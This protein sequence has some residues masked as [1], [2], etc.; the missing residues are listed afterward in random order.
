MA[1]SL[2][3]QEHL[4]TQRRIKAAQRIGASILLLMLLAALAGLFGRGGPMADARATQGP[5][6]VTAP[7]FAR[8]LAPTRIEVRIDRAPG[9]SV[10]VALQGE[11]ADAFH[12]RT[13]EPRPDRV[14]TTGDA[15]VYRFVAVPGRPHRM[16][17]DGQMETI[18]PVA[19]SVRVEGG[20]AVE[21]DT[22]VYP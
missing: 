20:P 16:R 5:L 9:D 1:R 22:F 7:R 14:A 10:T 13:I 17:F 11:L 2:E 4:P 3:I 18:G 19:G 15:T 21:T 8:Y 12:A 6:E